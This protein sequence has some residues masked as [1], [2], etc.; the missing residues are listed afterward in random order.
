[1]DELRQDF[2]GDGGRKC[3]TCKALD[4]PTRRFGTRRSMVQLLSFPLSLNAILVSSCAIEMHPNIFG[5][6]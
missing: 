6:K 5:F 1:V 4:F 2:W 3:D